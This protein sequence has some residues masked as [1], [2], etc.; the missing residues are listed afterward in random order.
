V[1]KAV[2]YDLDDLMVNSY[3]LHSIASDEVLK[4][5]GVDLKEVNDMRANFVGMRISDIL[6]MIVDRFDLKVS[7]GKLRKERSAIF[8]KLVREKL[9]SMPGLLNSLELI[10]KKDFKIAIASSGTREY[11]NTVIAKFKISSYFD[12]IVSGDDV[13]KGKPDPE[14][15]IVTSKKMGLD[16]GEIVVLEDATNGI[17]AAKSAGCWCI[18][19][20]NPYTPYQDLSKADLFIDSLGNL[21]LKIINSFN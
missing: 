1:V 12:L 6:K 9:K 16:P 7:M 14:T 21:S 11:I 3:P 18:A 5:Y 13:K 19:I 17:A 10:K 20:K 15:Y 2:V 4:K 8:L